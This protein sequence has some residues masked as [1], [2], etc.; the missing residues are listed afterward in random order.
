LSV[1]LSATETIAS[2]NEIFSHLSLSL[3]S[4]IPVGTDAKKYF[5]KM[6]EET[7]LSPDAQDIFLKKRKGGEK[8]TAA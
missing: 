8:E 7:T 4:H 6:V 2:P 5:M 1:E 3:S